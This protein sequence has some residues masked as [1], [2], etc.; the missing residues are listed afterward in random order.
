MTETNNNSL[1][2]GD[3][4][5]R[6]LKK[7]TLV[8]GIVAIMLGTFLNII[9]SLYAKNTES[10]VKEII[11]WEVVRL[12]SS[13]LSTGGVTFLS[14]A[15]IN[16]M[17]EQWRDG[18]MKNN[19]QA[20][21]TNIH[22]SLQ[23]SMNKIDTQI[24]SLPLS[25]KDNISASIEQISEN[26][27]SNINPS[28][29]C[30][31]YPPGFQTDD[32]IVNSLKKSIINSDGSYYYTGIG[33]STMSKSIM[34]ITDNLKDAYFLIPNPNIVDDDEKKEMY[35]S[36]TKMIEVWESAKQIK[37]E[38]ILMDYIPPFHI[39]KT[40]KD[41]WFA[42]LDKGWKNNKQQRQKYPATYQYKKN[43]DKSD[44]N[45]E[46]YHTIANTVDKLYNRHQNSKSYI[47][48][49]GQEIKLPRNRKKNV[50]ITCKSD[51]HLEE[52]NKADFL[53]LFT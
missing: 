8:I 38:F 16:L 33:M 40:S 41:C 14:V 31:I 10:S 15:L 46:L 9:Y 29:P 26:V 34:D 51:G 17:Y 13:C 21:N 24:Q 4:I 1:S 28:V 25:I 50:S 20:M 3:K 52:F 18:E 49:K 45:Y 36:V 37:L 22:N 35:T 32:P 6:I 23:S 2:M 42:F 30:N 48:M 43:K 12:L 7:G 44:D 5:K 47:F 11:I 27:T 19:I 53:K 39:H